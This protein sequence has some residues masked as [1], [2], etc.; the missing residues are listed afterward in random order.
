MNDAKEMIN[1]VLQ[2]DV[3]PSLTFGDIY[4]AK[5]TEMRETG[6]MVTLYP[7][8]VPTLLPNSQLDQRKVHHP[9]VLGLNVGEEIQVKYFGRDPVNG[10]IRLSRKVLQDPITSTRNFSST[11]G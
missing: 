5:I 11:K 2:K 1:E 7:A 6:V 3:E 4:T 10:R 8:M 9:S